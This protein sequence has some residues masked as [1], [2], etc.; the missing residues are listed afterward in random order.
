VNT[1]ISKIHFWDNQLISFILVFTVAQ[2]IKQTIRQNWLFYKP[3]HLFSSAILFSRKG[4]SKKKKE[5]KK[6]KG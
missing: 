2:I 5:R 4:D 3:S 6:K 1:I